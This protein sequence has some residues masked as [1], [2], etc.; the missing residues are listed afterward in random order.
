[1]AWVTE[2]EAVVAPVL[3]SR[4]PVY[5]V[6]VS[7]EVPSQLS[8]TFTTGAGGAVLGAA[9]PEPGRL[10]QPFTVCVTVYVPDRVTDME[11]VVA[12]VLHSNVPVY[13]DAVSREVP[14]QLSVTFTT[15]AGGA[16]G[17][18]LSVTGVGKEIHPAALVAVTSYIP[19]ASPGNMPVALETTGTT[20][21]VPVTE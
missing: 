15:G 11:A 20:G 13:P 16:L 6:A 2:M 14:L 18:A 7:R 19:G 17:T 12:P 21:L 1:M 10:T 8:V 9:V 3:H 5:P 4:V